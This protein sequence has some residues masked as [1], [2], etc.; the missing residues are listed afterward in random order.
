MKRRRWLAPLCI[1]PSLLVA[2]RTVVADD[3]VTGTVA[4][5]LVVGGLAAAP[6]NADMRV[7]LTGNV[8]L[9]TGTLTT[10]NWA[11]LNISDPNYKS[12][13]AMLLTAQISGKQVT[14]ISRPA[15]VGGNGTYCQIVYAFMSN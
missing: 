13:L 8:A 12:M 7:Y 14:V 4:Q 1:L 10:S 3:T 2:S 9:C 6:G 15:S 11:F 5:I